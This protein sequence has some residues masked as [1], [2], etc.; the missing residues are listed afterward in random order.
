MYNMSR[1]FPFGGICTEFKLGN[2]G[3]VTKYIKSKLMCNFKNTAAWC[4]EFLRLCHTNRTR[5]SCLVSCMIIFSHTL[6][7][8]WQQQRSK[9]NDG[10]SILT[11]VIV[12]L[13]HSDKCV[14]LSKMTWFY[15][16]LELDALFVQGDYLKDTHHFLWS[17]AQWWWSFGS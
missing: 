7:K 15:H 17:P 16:A 2:Q 1:T 5:G 11:D 10:F 4:K 3:E 13:I 12:S 9:L 14:L 8:M 6:G